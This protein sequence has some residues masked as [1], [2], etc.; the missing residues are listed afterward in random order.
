MRDPMGQRR[1][2]SERRTKERLRELC[3][4]VL[5]SYRLAVGEDLVTSEDR[6]VAEQYLRSMTPNLAG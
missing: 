5:A 2:R 1:I 4:E 3:D 6:E